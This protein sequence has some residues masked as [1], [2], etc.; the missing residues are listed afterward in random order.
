MFTSLIIALVLVGLI[1]AL[2]AVLSQDGY[3]H[4]P[5]PRSHLDPFDPFDPFN[6]RHNRFV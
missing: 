5:A 6:N 1:V 4:R 2:G 3:G